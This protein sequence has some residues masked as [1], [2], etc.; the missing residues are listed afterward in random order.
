M[1]GETGAAVLQPPGAPSMPTAPAVP[2]TPSTESRGSGGQKVEGT[3][4]EVVVAKPTAVEPYRSTAKAK[5]IEAMEANLA[6][7]PP[8]VDAALSELASSTATD[9][10]VHE[11]N[12][13]TAD[14]TTDFIEGEFEESGSSTSVT[15]VPKEITINISSPRP[16][17]NTTNSSQKA[18]AESGAQTLTNQEMLKIVRKYEE[19][20]SAMQKALVELGVKLSP[21]KQE[22]L[23]NQLPI[24]EAPKQDEPQAPE[25]TAPPIPEKAVSPEMLKRQAEEMRIL[26][27]N[28]LNRQVRAYREQLKELRGK[29]PADREKAFADNPG[30]RELEQMAMAS[31][32]ISLPAAE[33]MVYAQDKQLIIQRE[34]PD[35]QRSTITIAKLTSR[36][37]NGIFTAEQV[38][39]TLIELTQ[40]EVTDGLLQ[41]SGRDLLR[42]KTL[43]EKAKILLAAKIAELD[44]QVINPERK[45]QI[46]TDAAQEAGILTTNDVQVA[47]ANNLTPEVQTAPEVQALLQNME[48]KNIITAQDFTQALEILGANPQNFE[49]EI[50]RLTTQRKELKK[51]GN[52]EAVAIIDQQLAVFESP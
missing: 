34:T 46:I 7:K 26:Q 40:Q 18:Q 31:G 11:T 35:G 12:N 37:S 47:L 42:L 23:T 39:G 43:P 14:E 16:D 9:T 24:I 21:D 41:V 15:T 1:S 13:K 2:A 52:N 4:R 32:E 49:A 33:G 22:P 19:R 3:G 6:E 38:D 10:Q 17:K 20:I 44:G 50:T 51:A 5:L 25:N 8:K 28:I 36:N 27:E 30:L 29:S 48:G 45:N